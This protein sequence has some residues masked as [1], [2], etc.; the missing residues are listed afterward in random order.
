LPRRCWREANTSISLL[1]GG[2][3]TIGVMIEAD[4]L[5][6]PA[7][8]ITARR[9]SG[10]ACVVF[11]AIAVAC[12]TT[13]SSGGSDDGG[14]ERGDTGP[15]EGGGGEQG[16]A[17]ATD[18]GDA[19][20]EPP[21]CPANAPVAGTPCP[22]QDGLACTYGGTECSPC[23]WTMTCTAGSWAGGAPPC[24]APMP[25]CPPVKPTAGTPCSWACEAQWQCGYPSCTGPIDGV[26]IC[27]GG[28][29]EIP[30]S[31]CDAGLE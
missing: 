9:L 25:P 26:A 7:S 29:W 13:S 27:T 2:S 31:R 12:G 17:D 20:A 28:A 4:H 23:A 3:S 19:A 21:G 5:R 6:V 24:R 11:S 8:M 30:A 14:S 10:T 22:G 15:A 1:R 18:A 16:N